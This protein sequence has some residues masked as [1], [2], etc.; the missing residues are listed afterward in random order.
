MT[1]SKLCPA[2]VQPH[3]VCTSEHSSC[4]VHVRCYTLNIYQRL[5]LFCP[6][7][8]ASASLEYLVTFTNMRINCFRASH[9][10]T[11]RE[12]DEPAP[13]MPSKKYVRR[14]TSGQSA[15]SR[16]STVSNASISKLPPCKGMGDPRVEALMMPVPVEPMPSKCMRLSRPKAYSD[17]AESMRQTKGCRD[18]RSFPVFH[19]LEIDMSKSAED[20][21]RAVR[22]RTARY[23]QTGQRPNLGS[24][25]SMFDMI[26]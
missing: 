12:N 16:C 3:S 26:G 6:L 24:N 18:W 10:N 7:I 4:Q 1:C 20:Y 17:I 19:D 14:S 15:G 23:E 5:P 2:R 22:G 21:A 25:D 11:N 13:R 8:R 9:G